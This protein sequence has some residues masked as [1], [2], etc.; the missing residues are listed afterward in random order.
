LPLYSRLCA[1]A[2][3]NPCF[4]H[5]PCMRCPAAA[6]APP[7]C[8]QPSRGAGQ[9][10]H[11]VGSSRAQGAALVSRHMRAGVL[12]QACH[13]LTCAGLS[14]CLPHMRAGVLE[15]RGVSWSRAQGS[16]SVFVK[17]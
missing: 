9:P 15:Q 17:H 6:L 2:P 12:E 4:C 11:P 7:A 10:M 8:I 16:A 5:A 3:A 1:A 13:F 14:V